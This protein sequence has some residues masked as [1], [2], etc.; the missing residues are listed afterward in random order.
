MLVET[1]IVRHLVLKG[2]CCKKIYEIGVESSITGTATYYGGGGGA[3]ANGQAGGNGG[4]G[5]GGN[6]GG[7]PPLT[8]LV[9]IPLSSRHW[10][11]VGGA[12]YQTA[13]S[14]HGC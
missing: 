4:Q 8:H 1:Q 11:E 13:G 5:G 12:R 3:S 7:G 2:N 10:V 6:A 9:D 14:S